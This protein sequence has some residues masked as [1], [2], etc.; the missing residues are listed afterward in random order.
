MT[1]KVQGETYNSPEEVITAI[2]ELSA[3]LEDMPESSKERADLERHI[4]R[5]Q[6]AVPTE[7][8][9]RP[10]SPTS[11]EEESEV[12]ESP[13]IQDESPPTPAAK[14]TA[15]EEDD[16][17]VPPGYK[18]CRVCAGS[19]L[20]TEDA[21]EDPDNERC[22]TCTG[23]GKVLTGSHVEGHEFRDCP[24]C[25]GNGYTGRRSAYAPPTNG[26]T[27][28]VAPSWPGATWNEAEERWDP[29]YGDP[30]WTGATW[31]SLKGAYA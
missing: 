12:V 19:G 31:D 6:A 29:P 15:E 25:L 2:G 13:N 4:R 26:N 10:P 18:L 28:A 14:P 20:L 3:T 23:H 24:S 17:A 9:I 1:I 30:P 27:A 7:E 21:P 22:P 8:A 5:L 11:A 16:D